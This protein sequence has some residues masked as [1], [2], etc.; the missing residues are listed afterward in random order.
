M[1]T[2]IQ[3]EVVGF[4]ELIN[5]YPDDPDFAKA[6]K[7]C[8]VPI[9][10]D[11]MKWLDFL[12]QDGML[13]KGNKL[14]IPRNPTRENLIKEKHSHGLVGYFGLDKTFTLVVENYY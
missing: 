5:L 13:F 4:K 11:R 2:Q 8:I 9:T 10:L 3:I 14:C 12:I 7:A 6:W 1:L